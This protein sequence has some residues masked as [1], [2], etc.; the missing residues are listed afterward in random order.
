MNCPQY[1]KNVTVLS[2]LKSDLK[3]DGLEN[4]WWL[5]CITTIEFHGNC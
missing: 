2:I 4:S 1:L 3:M 5:C